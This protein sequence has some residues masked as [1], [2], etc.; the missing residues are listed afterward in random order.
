MKYCYIFV[1][2]MRINAQILFDIYIN[3]LTKMGYGII[4]IIGSIFDGN[5]VINS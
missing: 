5:N 2:N 4:I 1:L 3:M